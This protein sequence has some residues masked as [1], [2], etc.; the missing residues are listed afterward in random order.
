MAL[1][2]DPEPQVSPASDGQDPEPYR[3]S[4]DVD[5]VV[6]NATVSDRQGG[7]ATGLREQDFAV[8]ED[9]VRKVSGCSGTKIS[10]SPW[11][12][13]RPQWKHAAQTR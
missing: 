13:C 12:G 7:F 11:A 9:G 2:G 4:V 1:G 10:R 5:L 8:Y 3:I 6:L